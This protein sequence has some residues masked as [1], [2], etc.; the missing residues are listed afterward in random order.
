MYMRTGG[1]SVAR[2]RRD[3]RL[4]TR[5]A[6]LRLAVRRDPYFR[7]LEKGVSLGYRRTRS[8]GL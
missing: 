7:Q 6:R 8:A 2:K 5:E 4:E 1:V 3:A